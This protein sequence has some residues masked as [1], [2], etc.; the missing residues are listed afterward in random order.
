MYREFQDTVWDYYHKHGRDLPWRH[1]EPD[2]SFD[3]Y[4]IM[5]SEIMLQQTQAVRVIPKYHE[6]LALFPDIS[7]LAKAPLSAVLT[8]WS[9]LGYNRRAKFLW[10]AAQQVGGPFPDTIDEL[11]KLP[12]IGK[13]TAAAIM[14]YSFNT[15]VAFIE[16][17]IRSVYIHHFFADRTDVDDKELLELVTATIDNEHPREWFW[18]LMDYGVYIKSTIGNTARNSKHY[19]KQSTFQ[20]S[21]RQVR[22]QV[23]RLLTAGPMSHKELTTNIADDRLTTVLSD[24]VKEGLVVEDSEVYRLC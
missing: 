11:V 3:P 2:G 20:G 7:T 8:T 24:L 13:N 18:A 1:A 6:F 10:Q 21:K 22:G 15:P 5:V 16:T 4:K 17:N 9:G 14:A 12:G 19:A 23:I